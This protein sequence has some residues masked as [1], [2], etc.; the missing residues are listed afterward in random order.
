MRRPSDRGSL[1]ELFAL[2]LPALARFLAGLHRLPSM[3]LWIPG[4]M[5]RPGPRFADSAGGK[6]R[7]GALI[8]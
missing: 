6:S 8:R 7:A 5:K 4:R 2:E 3:D 1:V